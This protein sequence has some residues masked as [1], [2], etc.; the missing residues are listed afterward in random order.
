LPLDKRNF[1][2]AEIVTGPVSGGNLA[3]FPE[4]RK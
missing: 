3:W 4:I 1:T 2:V